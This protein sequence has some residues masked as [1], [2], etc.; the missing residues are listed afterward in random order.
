MS[1]FFVV[2]SP[3]NVA[4]GDSVA[5]LEAWL[6][7]TFPGAETVAEDGDVSA[8]RWTWS[9]STPE[10]GLEG[11]VSGDLTGVF[12]Q[13]DL[14]SICQAALA[15]VTLFPAEATVVLVNESQLIPFDLRRFSD[16]TQLAEAIL[17]DDDALEWHASE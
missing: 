4:A 9:G 16:R 8:L 5:T 6:A 13:G 14:E 17:N 3:E 12:L 1:S 10:H 15:A 2:C 7:A 11:W